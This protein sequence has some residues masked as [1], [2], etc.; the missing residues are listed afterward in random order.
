MN[1]SSC[2]SLGWH[3]ITSYDQMYFFYAEKNENT[4]RMHI[5]PELE[6][7][8]QRDSEV[9]KIKISD[10][11]INIYDEKYRQKILEKFMN[12]I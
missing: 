3:F 10:N 9:I 11:L 12:Y 7:K 4:Y 1:I 6:Q 5:E 8:L 2:E